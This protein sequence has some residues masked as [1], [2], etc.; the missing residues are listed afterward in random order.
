MRR[1]T[2]KPSM[3]GS[4]MSSTT[5]RT[6]WRPQLGERLLAGPEPGDAPAVLLLEVLLD[7]PADRVVVLDEEKDTARCP[8]AHGLRIVR[9]RDDVARRGG[10]PVCLRVPRRNLLHVDRLRRCAVRRPGD[11]ARASAARE[12]SPG[13]D[14]RSEGRRSCCP[15][16]SAGRG[17]RASRSVTCVLLTWVITPRS[18]V[19]LLAVPLEHLGANIF[20]PKSCETTALR[21][22]RPGAGEEEHDVERHERA[23]EKHETAG[24]VSIFTS[25]PGSSS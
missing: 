24:H 18:S 1:Q 23:G 8:R 14:G 11:D 17:R 6:G 7:E 16:G 10:S 9:R 13:S 4:P 12:R 2:S 25:L 22:A 5:S 3:P 20:G 19:P 15:A 21:S